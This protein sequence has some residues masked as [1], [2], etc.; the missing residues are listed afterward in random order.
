MKSHRPWMIWI[1]CVAVCPFC[2]ESATWKKHLIA[3]GGHCNTALAFSVN[4]D[5]LPDVIASYAGKVSLFLAPTWEKEVVLHRFQQP[6][7]GCI[8]STSLD[9]DGDGD[10]DWAGALSSGHP[11]WLENPGWPAAGMGAWTARVIDEAITGI[12]CLLTADVDQDGR[13]D[14]IINNFEPAR[15]IQ[16]SIAW[17]SVPK[18]PYSANAWNRH[19]FA[20]GDARGGSHYMGLGDVN[21]DGWMEIAVGAKGRPFQEGNWFAFW[22]HPGSSEVRQPWSKTVLA[23]D[24]PGATSVLGIDVNQDGKTDWVASRGH[25]VGLLWFENPNWNAHPIDQ[26]IRSPHSLTSAD[27]NL[28]GLPDVASC[29]YESRWVRWYENSGKGTF[30]THQI[31]S[32]QESYDLRSLDM[33]GDGDA[34]LLNAGRGSKNV[35]WYENPNR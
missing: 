24:E 1:A 18:N 5:A 28:D 15:G 29:G 25:G 12:H 11:F 34:D 3:E 17:L 35:V 33:D 16:D 4:E 14:V 13:D 23:V 30:I 32:D 20:S 8:H 6:G 9:V 26:E 31:D 10:M 19:V 7:A 22:T 2:L 27:Y 21:G